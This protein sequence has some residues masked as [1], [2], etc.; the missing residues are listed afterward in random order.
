MYK[1]N[2]NESRIVEGVKVCCE[3]SRNS[4]Y[5]TRPNIMKYWDYDG[6]FISPKLLKPDMEEFVIACKCPKCGYRWHQFIPTDRD[7]VNCSKCNGYDS[8]RFKEDKHNS[9]RQAACYYYLKKVI[10]DLELNYLASNCYYFDLYSK[11]LN[12]IIEIDSKEFHQFTELKDADNDA[13]AKENGITI[14][15]LNP[16]YNGEFDNINE[17]ARKLNHEYFDYLDNRSCDMNDGVLMCLLYVRDKYNIDVSNIDIDC[18]RDLVKINEIR[19]IYD[20][21]NEL[22]D[23]YINK[24]KYT[25]MIKIIEIIHFLPGICEAF[26]RKY[27]YINEEKVSKYFFKYGELLQNVIDDNSELFK[28]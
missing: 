2:T 5:Y 26:Y 20:D 17:H 19:N 10:D 12:L 6:N 3:P 8:Y 16:Q 18:R 27:G 9:L 24:G 22:G 21:Y 11:S 7:H 13:F 23:E 4:I 15:R 1:Y 14:A 25:G 28:K